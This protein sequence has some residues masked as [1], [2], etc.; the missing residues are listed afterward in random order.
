MLFRSAVLVEQLRVRRL[1]T[2]VGKAG[3]VE[4]VQR[5]RSTHQPLWQRRY[6]DLLLL[7]P[8]YYGYRQLKE[9]GTISILGRTPAIPST[10][11]DSGAGGDPFTDPLLILTPAFCLLALA[12][13]SVRI[14]PLIMGFAGYLTSRLP[15][16]S[17]L[18]ALRYLTR[19]PRAYIGPVDRKSVV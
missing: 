3:A 16:V 17:G 8:A 15:G 7:I 18:L 11:G 6:L 9:R 13:L 10:G 12:L 4:H 5:A 14:F 1:E 19:A 2:Y